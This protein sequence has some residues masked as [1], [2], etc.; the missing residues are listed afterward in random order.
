MHAHNQIIEIM[1]FHRRKPR[2]KICYLAGENGR[3]SKLSLCSYIKCHVVYFQ[4]IREVIVFPFSKGRILWAF[5]F[6][7]YSHQEQHNVYFWDYRV[8]WKVVFLGCV[9]SWMTQFYRFFFSE[10]K[11]DSFNLIARILILFVMS[12]QFEVQGKEL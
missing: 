11:N 2:K 9:P 6:A 8:E 7:I 5:A 10:S 4:K 1:Q 3:A 12:G